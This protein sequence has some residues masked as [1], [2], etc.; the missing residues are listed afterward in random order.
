L[1]SLPRDNRRVYP[2]ISNLHIGD[3][4]R[5]EIIRGTKSRARGR[6]SIRAIAGYRE[7]SEAI[8]AAAGTSQATVSHQ[9]LPQATAGYYRQ[10]YRRQSYRRELQEYHSYDRATVDRATA[11]SYKNI[12]AT[13]ELPQTELP[14]GAT[15]ISELPQSYHRATTELLQSYHRATANQ[16]EGLKWVDRLCGYPVVG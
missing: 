7:T 2:P 9:R 15:G 11:G 12:T 3:Q 14:Q 13:I 16:C 1:T 8:R 6:Y 4:R 5:D 10:S